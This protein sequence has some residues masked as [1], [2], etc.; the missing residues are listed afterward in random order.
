MNIK[1]LR[2]G[3]FLCLMTSTL[4]FGLAQEPAAPA[5]KSPSETV[6]GSKETAMSYVLGSEDVIRISVINFPNLSTQLTIPPD[7]VISVP[8]LKPF[9][10]LG[11]TTAEVAK[12]LTEQWDMYAVNPSVDVALTQRRRESLFIYGFIV[13]PGTFE[14]KDKKRVLE[15]I[16][17]AGGFTPLAD[18]KR[19]TVTHKSGVKQ[20]L[21]LTPPETKSRTDVDIELEV[22][23]VIYIP[24]RRLQISVL[25]EVIRPGSMDYKEEMTVLDAMAIVG[26]VRED[27]ADL[28]G[29]RLTHAGKER[30]LNMRA[31]LRDAD[32]SQNIKLAPGDSLLIPEIRSRVYV[33]G[34]VN[35]QGYYIFKQGDRILDALNGMGGP[36]PNGNIK[37]IY[38][39]QV[40]K[41]TKTR[42]SQQIDLEKLL[43]GKDKEF[44]QNLV[45]SAGDILYIPDKKRPFQIQEAFGL[46]TGFATL[47][48]IFQPFR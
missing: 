36:N 40:D 46:L 11:K 41:V 34:A 39:L 38:V 12:Y 24:E 3:W 2:L 4:N 14:F 43:K 8:L 27:T 37:E 25:G 26:G 7:G 21:D 18:W 48:S 20:S 5:G 47:Y 29:A 13:R 19:V 44:K 30:P 35:R 33:Y 6:A 31:L 1:A 17:E 32:L 10:V 28:E 15:V 16:A 23:D 42:R 22:G 9:S 45:L